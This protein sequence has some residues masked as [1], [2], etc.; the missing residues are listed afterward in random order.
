MKSKLLSHVSDV[1]LSTRNSTALLDLSKAVAIIDSLM[2]LPKDNSDN[3]KPTTS[4]TK[5]S[6]EEVATST[7]AGSKAI[8]NSIAELH[9]S[10][11]ET[12]KQEF[13]IT[14]V[15][16][17]VK[18]S[19]KTAKIKRRAEAIASTYSSITSITSKCMVDN[20]SGNVV[21]DNTMEPFTKHQAEFAIRKYLY[22][23]YAL[24]KGSRVPRHRIRPTATVLRDKTYI[25]PRGWLK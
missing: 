3:V 18:D 12:N 2:Y 15:S 23:E 7:A 11:E 21:K 4:S 13:P 22:D 9:K 14:S 20:I 6:N 19:P 25:V 10:I 17:E 5:V 16:N 24:V 1:F 8:L